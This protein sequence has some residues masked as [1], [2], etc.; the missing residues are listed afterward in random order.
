MIDDPLIV[1]LLIL[2]F[3]LILSGF[4]SA[5]E[6]SFFSIH[7]VKLEALRK[8]DN[9][10][11]EIVYT[12]M[13]KPRKLLVTIY[14]GNEVVNVGI[15][16]IIT[17]I[18][19]HIMGPAGIIPAMIIS[20]I[21]LLQFGEIIPKTFAIS[22]P[23]R[24]AL[25]AA[26][27]IRWFAFLIFPLQFLIT[28][29]ANI[30]ITLLG[31]EKLNREPT[32]SEEEI[33]TLINIG[34]EEGALPSEEKEMIQSVFD[35][36]DTSISEVMT[37]R[38]D[39]ISIPVNYTLESILSS[40]SK[41]FY[42]RIPVYKGNIDTIVGILYSRDLLQYLDGKKKITNLQEILHQPF[43]VPG[44]RKVNDLLKDFQKKKVHL[45]IVL[46]EHGGVDGLVTLDDLMEELFGDVESEEEI[47]SLESGKFRIS[48]SIPIDDFN[49]K[50]GTRIPHDEFD[51]IG[52]YVFHAIGE[53][54]KRGET[55]KYE[56]LEFTVEKMK[57][58]R[59][60]SLRLNV[61]EKAKETTAPGEEEHSKE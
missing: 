1:R 43:I 17:S 50:M 8:G 25:F 20:L 18:M 57:G 55:V 39:I 11:G 5:C 26:Q 6:A 12:L 47:V 9:K 21:L 29:I 16:A 52:G 44:S 24:F 30:S 51:T 48:G 37:P 56:H 27:P 61:I 49:K 59:I 41:S 14:L 19:I 28:G 15:A 31:G 23:E 46:D 54:P 45:A 58:H 2:F 42:S 34:E 60:L 38:T 10:A 40:L 36:G 53:A 13:Q 7:G 3:F 22:N 33:R 35:L 4:F 32:V